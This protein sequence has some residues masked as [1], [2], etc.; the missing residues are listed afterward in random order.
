MSNNELDNNKKLVKT[1]SNSETRV[2]QNCGRK[3]VIEPE[4]FEFYKKI[5]VPPPTFCPDCRLQRRMAFR[6]ERNLYKR[7]C[8]FSGKNIISIYH[9]NSPY[10]VYDQKI[11]WS[12]KWDPMN[13]GRDYDFNRPFFEQFEELM[14]EVPRQKMASQIGS[15]HCDYTFDA[16]YSKNCY[17]CTVAIDS[18]DLYYSDKV[19]NSNSIFD[20]IWVEKSEICYECIDCTRAYSS[21]FCQ[22]SDNII[23]SYFLYN[24]KNCSNCFGCVNLKNK[25]YYIFNKPYSK[26]EYFKKI[27]ELDLG[28][29]KNLIGNKSKFFNHKNR[30]PKKFAVLYNSRNVIGNYIRNSKNCKFCFDAQNNL[31]NCKYIVQAGLGLKDSYDDYDVGTNSELLYECSGGGENCRKIFLNN[32]VWKGCYNVQYSD[33]CY[34]SHHLFGCI[35]LRHKQYCILN[36]QYTKEEYEKLVPKIIEQMNKL[37][38]KDKKGRVYKYG[39]FFPIELSPFAYN[40]TVAQEYFPLTKEEAINQGYS[41]YD[42]PKSEYQPTIK[43]EDLPDHIKDVDDS[44]TQE[45]IECANNS[46]G[47]CQGSGVYRILPQ[48]LEFYRKMNLPLPRLCPAC[49]HQERI[50]QRNPMKLYKRRC[51]CGGETSTNGVYKN[52]AKHFHNQ[53]RCPNEFYTTYPPESPE[54]VYCDECYKREVE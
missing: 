20:S 11:W 44:I 41:W 13:Y 26:E 43:A 6:N 2:C 29:Y 35:G 33:N 4:D 5:N 31:E 42:R 24:C 36:K 1:M 7:K 34:S 3:F 18:R 8:D 49:R 12:D 54:I 19:L 16:W 17:L 9:P 32:Q 46:S 38:Y 48:E 14:R 10:K 40:E 30:F 25:Q 37:P 47:K 52:T 53:D 21:I 45:I 22:N 23:N 50:K 15:E 27:E 51:M 39:E 28:G